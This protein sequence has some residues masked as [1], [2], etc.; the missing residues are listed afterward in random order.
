MFWGYPCF[1][2]NPYV[3]LESD[4]TFHSL[5]HFCV[6]FYTWHSIWCFCPHFW[7]CYFGGEH[8]LLYSM[9]SAMGIYLYIYIFKYAQYTSIFICSSSKTP[10]S[11]DERWRLLPVVSS[12]QFCLAGQ[13]FLQATEAEL[14]RNPNHYSITIPLSQGYSL[15]TSIHK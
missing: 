1:E 14:T 8:P 12:H 15:V 11:C 7:G 3:P 10:I 9:W 5:Y 13:G 6:V 2:K 4:Y